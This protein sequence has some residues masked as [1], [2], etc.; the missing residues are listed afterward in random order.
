MK[1][2]IFIISLFLLFVTNFEAL[3]Y[4]VA[5]NFRFP[6]DNYG[7]GGYYF[8]DP[9]GGGGLHAGVDIVLRPGIPVY[10]SAD[11]YVKL[12]K[13]NSQGYE[14]VVVIEHVLPSGEMVCTIYGHLSEKPE[15][16]LTHVGAINAGD[17]VG[18]VGWDY[19]NGIGGPHLH[20]G[21]RKGEYISLYE[22]R[23]SAIN[24]FYDPTLFLLNNMV[25]HYSDGFRTNGT[26]QAFIDAYNKVKDIIGLPVSR[27]GGGIFVHEWKSAADPSYSVWIQDFYNPKT[28]RW[29]A[30]VL[31]DSKSNPEVFLLQGAILN[32]YVSHDGPR[33]CGVPFT[34]EIKL[35]LAN[36]L[37]TLS[38]DFVRPAEY[39]YSSAGV[40][41]KKIVVQKFM[42]RRNGI[43]ETNNRHTVVHDPSNGA[44][45]DFAV[46]EYRFNAGSLLNSPKEGDQLYL[47]SPGYP[48]Q[49]DIP[50]PMSNS[51]I[52]NGTTG[53]WFVKSGRYDFV[54]HNPN[55]T[56]KI[57]WGLGF[58]IEEGNF[59]F[60]GDSNPSGEALPL[61]PTHF[62]V[63][64]SVSTYNGVAPFSPTI[65]NESTGDGLTCSWYINGVEYFGFNLEHIFQDFGDYL[66]TL[67]AQDQYGNCDLKQRLI[68]VS[69]PELSPVVGS[70][71]Y[72]VVGSVPL[73]V[74]YGDRSTDED[75]YFWN[76]GDG[77]T[78]TLQSGQHI[79]TEPGVYEVIHQ[80]INSAGMD[81]E[82]I[83]ITVL[84]SGVNCNY[85]LCENMVGAEFQVNTGTVDDQT[86]ASVAMI[87][88]GAVCVWQSMSQDGSGWGVY[89][90]MYDS[91]FRKIGD[92]FLIPAFTVNNQNTPKVFALPN[93]FVV[94]WISRGQD[95]EDNV[96]LQRFDLLGAKK[97]GEELVNT[98]TTDRQ[99]NPEI[100]VDSSGRLVVVWESRWQDGDGYGIFAQI[101][102]PDGSRRG[103]EFQINTVALGD[104]TSPDVDFL[105]NGNLIV[106]WKSA[107]GSETGVYGKIID[108]DKLIIKEE[109]SVNTIF[110]N[111][112]SVPCIAVLTDGNFVVSWD[113]RNSG[114]YD[115]H[116]QIFD[117]QGLVRGQE[118]VV[119]TYLDNSQHGS[120]IAVLP[121][122]KF[123]ITWQS[124]MQFGNNSNIFARIFEGSGSASTGEFLVNTHAISN[125][126]ISSSASALYGDVSVV[127]T[128]DL[129]DGDDGGVFGQVFSFDHCSKEQLKKVTGVKIKI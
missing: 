88:G 128:S 101:F 12:V 102:N 103:S 77:S 36:S 71:V 85:Q 4:E 76:F 83:R 108:I 15:Y 62:S 89:G 10:A 69:D 5:K 21:I 90:Q 37:L 109:F 125:K 120:C 86:A 48:Y 18:H 47:A 91:D 74:T 6:V 20:F 28:N 63:D 111:T 124:D 11:G 38:S 68:K 65:T 97:G 44:T 105:H 39:D 46:G 78:S 31:N 53:S 52:K 1:K 59:Q 56:R 55:G 104:Q 9:S 67:Y 114:D 95:G 73:T 116:A 121:G 61:E 64:F 27:S 14:Q 60:A 17:I 81:E 66:I 32:H 8:G 92:E 40:A 54:L 84:P 57:G 112:Q 118:F 41:P 34:R 123:L 7:V 23:S 26:S 96:Y 87:K 115:V 113:S 129:Q 100:S 16:P 110:E 24:N 72:P 107:D 49:Q 117:T 106:V 22:G 94:V 93:G 126:T 35:G 119:N 51:P 43:C 122:N 29:F 3:S 50:W 13:T 98:Y 70:Q 45:N 2:K 25:G 127:W 19:E 42:A 80:A 82:I 79:F 58:P 75:S 33:T 30:L 99:K